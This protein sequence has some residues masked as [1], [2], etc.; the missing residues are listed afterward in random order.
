MNQRYATSVLSGEFTLSIPNILGLLDDSRDIDKSIMEM[1]TRDPSMMF[2]PEVKYA[3]GPYNILVAT[4]LQHEVYSF[5]YHLVAKPRSGYRI[6]DKPRDVRV[7]L[8]VASMS[9][10]DK[11]LDGEDASKNVIRAG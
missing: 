4:T 3:S 1:M 6:S 2:H 5:P 7:I 10:L 8:R 9:Y 11:H